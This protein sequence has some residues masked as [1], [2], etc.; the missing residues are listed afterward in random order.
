[1][2]QTN[3]TLHH[4]IS[5][6][7]RAPKSRLDCFA[8]GFE[9]A[10]VWNAGEQKIEFLEQEKIGQANALRGKLLGA[11]FIVGLIGAAQSCHHSDSSVSAEAT[12]AATPYVQPTPY[13]QPTPRPQ[14]TR[15]SDTDDAT[16]TPTVKRA[17]PVTDIKGAE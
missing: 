6:L 14:A 5:S 12:A 10:F 2:H 9:T 8:F 3:Q 11:A 17:L 1:M 4:N 16:P 15:Y 7:D 13:E